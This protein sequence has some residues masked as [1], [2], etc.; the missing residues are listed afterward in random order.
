MKK[1]SSKH[2][3]NW[4]V[5]LVGFCAACLLVGGDASAAII[6]WTDW[7]AATAGNPG[8]ANGTISLPGGG[9]ISVD[10]SG[11]VIL[12]TDIS[13]G[14]SFYWGPN[15]SNQR[16]PYTNAVVDNAPDSGDIIA[17]TGGTPTVNTIMFSAPVDNPVIAVFSLGLGNGGFARYEFNTAFNLLSFGQGCC[18]GGPYTLA[19]LPGNV[20]EG[21]EGNG[22]IQF[23]GRHS[24]ISWTVPVGEFWHG[25][26]VGIPLPC[27][28]CPADVVTNTAPGQCGRTLTFCFGPTNSCQ[29]SSGS[30]FPVGV[31]PVMC[32]ATNDAGNTNTC[33]FTVTISDTERPL[34]NCPSIIISS[35]APGRCDAVVNFSVEPIDN[36][37]GA[38]FSC[39][40][41]SGSVFQR[42]VTPVTCLAT[43]GVGNTNSCAFSVIVNDRER[44]RMTCP[45][46][47]PPRWELRAPFVDPR[48]TGGTGGVEGASASLIGDKIYVS[49]GFRSGDSWLL[50]V[51]HIPSNTWTH[52]GMNLP[53]A[54]SPRSEMAGG[55]AFGRHY[56][57]GGRTGPSAAVEEFDPATRLWQAKASLSVAR[58]GLAAA[59]YQD[60]IYALGGRTGSS[61]GR[62]IVTNI[63]EVYDPT[64]DTW[65]RLAPMPLAVS[66][67]Y[68][69]VAWNGR[70][71]VFGGTVRDWVGTTNVVQ[72]YDI[73]TNT[74]SLGSPMPTR[75]GAAMA[76]VIGGRIAVFGG[77]NGTSNLVVTEFYDPAANTWSAG[78]NMLQPMSEM[79]QGVTFNGDEIYA[80]GSG[81]FGAAEGKVQVL[82]GGDALKLT[83]DTD[84]G[85]CSKSNVT[86]SVSAT[87][88]CADITVPSV[89]ISCVP[90]N[91]S[92]FFVGTRTV[93]C[94][95][96]DTSENTTNCTFVV[97][98][99]DGERPVMNCS[100]LV[101]FLPP[102]QC[103][104]QVI[105]P[106]LATD[107]CGGQQPIGGVLSVI[108]QPQSG[109]FFLKGTTPVFCTASDGRGNVGNTQS[110]TFTVTVNLP[111]TGPV[112][113][114]GIDAEDDGG[115]GGHG[116]ITTWQTLV[117]NIL[118]RAIGGSG[119]L[120]IGA[121][122]NPNDH[123]THFWNG[124]RTGI[125]QSVTFVNGSAIATHSFTGYR[126][127]AVVSDYRNTFSGGLTVAENDLL[128]NRAS[129]VANFVHA[130]GGLLGFSSEFN[131]PP[132]A[133]GPY[134]Y[135][136]GLGGV[137]LGS[138]DYADIDPTPAGRAVGVDDSL[139]VFA[140]HQHFLSYPS[141]LGVLAYI[142]GTTNPA[143]IG[144]PNV[145]VLLTCPSP[146]VAPCPSASVTLTA[147]VFNA[148]CRDLAVVWSVDGSPVQ[149][150]SVPANSLSPKLT[151]ARTYGPGF[152]DVTVSFGG[153]VLAQTCRTVVI[154][155]ATPPTISCPGGA[156]NVIVT[157]TEPGQCSTIVT[158]SATATDDCTGV[159]NVT[160]SP[161]SGS[162]FAKGTN[163]V[164]CTATDAVGNTGTCSFQVIVNDLERPRL[165]CPADIVTDV[166]AGEPSVVV[167][168][169]PNATDNCAVVAVSCDP[170]SGSTFSNLT[171]TVLCTAADAAGNT[172]TCSFTVTLGGCVTITPLAN[173]A[174]CSKEPAAFS[175]TASGNGPFTYT[176][177][178]DGNVTGTNGPTL[179]VA[180]DSL[181]LGEHIVA[182]LVT[183]RCGSATNSAIL[184]VGANTTATG[185]TNLTRCIC[186]SAAFHT[187]V[188]GTPAARFVWKANGHVM[189][190]ETNSTLLLQS[191]KDSDA[192][193]YTVEVHGLCN[194]VTNSATLTLEGSSSNPLLLTNPAPIAIN[195]HPAT[196]SPYPSVIRVKC[197]PGIL[198][199]LT[200]TL[201][202]ISHSY[203]DDVDILLVNPAGQAIKLMSDAG[204][205][206]P[207]VDLR[208]GFEDAA[209]R[210]LFNESQL[211]NG[212]FRPSDYNEDGLDVFPG[213]APG[214]TYATNLAQ[215]TGLVPNGNW[216]LYIFD[217]ALADGGGI[218]R[219]WS[220]QL[221]WE[222]APARFSGMGF[223]SNGHFQMR[224]SGAA[225]RTHMVEASS[226]LEVWTPI[227]TNSVS[228]DTFIVIDPQSSNFPHRFY[229]AILCP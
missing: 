3:Q 163:E 19:V 154:V 191:L 99:R 61:Y 10:Y 89:F 134:A 95:A 182:L 15:L 80:I 158:F 5:A 209:S 9:N 24:S 198:T 218:A 86:F 69:T 41:P 109:S 133:A 214:G 17:L 224:L 107:N 118:N 64:L 46:T 197:V 192:G 26:T 219:G 206:A 102:G 205:G 49:H 147:Q 171:T 48:S 210:V 2:S 79:A 11:E 150:N 159:T 129:D 117:S 55:T 65:Q 37:P 38:S 97:T 138:L 144:G 177:T 143:A 104:M 162:T 67:H 186:E 172:A 220:M 13:G 196:A 121:G 84:P 85:R 139:D 200:V 82:L 229:R 52:G 7:T 212:V 6:S 151:L 183:N 96:R 215:L 141:Y 201:N 93:V 126:M 43:D 30:F 195:D 184:T 25:F 148:E 20:L 202:G 91:G 71:F 32:V 137:T 168:F 204:G 115:H 36:C 68:A 130:G 50:S 70:I 120:V 53:D 44:P 76:G 72:I 180:T 94:T 29:P 136:V 199:G 87:D 83:F 90:T 63:N 226:D 227:A 27:D 149:T 157:N 216:M 165:D 106:P 112:I 60:R 12:Q 173:A 31:T 222:A 176:W 40:P 103:Q 8:S 145:N 188:S 208:L 58:G 34:Q 185:P 181:S 194:R 14:A 167:V 225:G 135:M 127:L 100:N 51:Y 155:D 122:K 125:L 153:G 66:D 152:H 4:L 113:L 170:P 78:P 92:T 101:R 140:W 131:R 54:V 98:V 16:S 228:T 207:I 123:V 18:F 169:S 81:L 187:V 178:L 39:S 132:P 193:L 22:T 56:A 74:W 213:P 111:P 189:E 108:C 1:K 33:S 28:L 77:F 217:D 23:P 42:G 35:T 45:L 124:V 62:G 88:N 164:L 160:C 119:V 105:Y 175:T 73:A 110:C 190:G 114:M 166:P 179:T 146:F 47:Q 142:R 223:L 75:R 57:I 221:S 59:S 116:P 174:V 128:R 203:P 161:A 156:G 21:Q 211:T